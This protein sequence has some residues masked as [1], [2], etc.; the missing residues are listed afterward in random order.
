MNPRAK[1]SA[2]HNAEIIERIGIL[3]PLLT[4]KY[5]SDGIHYS[6]VYMIQW[7]ET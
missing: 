4:N 7:S 6:S 2:A 5:R 1:L 3:P